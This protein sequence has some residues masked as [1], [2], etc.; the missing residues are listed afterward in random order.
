[1]LFP[2]HEEQ[3]GDPT[4][5]RHWYL[6]VLNIKLK[7]FEV[8]DSMR[9]ENNQELEESVAKV[10]EVISKLWRQYMHERSMAEIVPVWDFPITYIPG[11]KQ[12]TK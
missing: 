7:R 11:Y 5:I 12:H 3:K 1:M 10:K 9:S 2:I 8:I 4:A 6:V